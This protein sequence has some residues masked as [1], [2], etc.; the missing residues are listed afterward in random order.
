[1]WL[2]YPGLFGRDLLH[3]V[4]E[5]IAVVESD[6]RDDAQFRIT[7]VRRVEASAESGLENRI[8]DLRVRIHEKRDGG[9]RLEESEVVGCD[10]RDLFGRGGKRIVANRRAVEEESF[11]ELDEMGR[12]VASDAQTVCAQRRVEHCADRA[13]SVGACDVDRLERLL[14]IAQRGAC[15]ADRVESGSHPEPA[16]RGELFEELHPRWRTISYIA[17]AAATPALSD[18][19]P[20]GIGSSAM[21]SHFSRT[22]REMPFPSAPTTSPTLPRKSIFV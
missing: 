11:V 22:R 9:K 18:S 4:A 6:A 2:Y 14:R 1:M 10:L 20:P 15:A 13:L 19:K 16:P 21:K 8:V 3:S 5:P 17:T 7:H 12:G